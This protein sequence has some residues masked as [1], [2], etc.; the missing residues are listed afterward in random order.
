MV[1]S[2]QSGGV[3]WNLGGKGFSLCIDSRPHFSVGG[4]GVKG[5]RRSTPRPKETSNVSRSS[6]RGALH[7]TARCQK[8]KWSLGATGRRPPADGRNH[9]HVV[10]LPSKAMETSPRN[11]P[12]LTFLFVLMGPQFQKN[13]HKTSSEQVAQKTG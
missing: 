12:V 2:H 8:G 13:T 11:K 10:I 7:C 9:L 1:V 4:Q 6:L 5:G 3:Q